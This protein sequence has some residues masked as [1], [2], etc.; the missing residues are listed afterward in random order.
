MKKIHI[1]IPSL[2][3][4]AA[5]PLATMVGCEDDIV[6]HVK[7]VKIDAPSKVTCWKNQ[8]LQLTCSVR[9]ENATNK[10]VKWESLNANV[11][12]I[13]EEGLVTGVNTGTT[14][15]TVQTDDGKYVDSCEIEIFAPVQG[16]TIDGEE[17]K[18]ITK[19]EQTTL[20]CTIDPE[21]AH[22]REVSWESSNNAVATID[23]ATGVV[24]AVGGGTTTITVTTRDG[25]FTD[26]CEI[27]VISLVES[28]SIADNIEQLEVGDTNQ[29]HYNI[30]P[31]DATDK[32]VTWASSNT[33]VANV[34][35]NGLVT[36]VAPGNATITVTTNDGQKT[37]N[38]TLNVVAKDTIPDF[39]KCRW[40]KIAEACEKYESG[41]WTIEQFYQ[42]FS[43][44]GTQV[45]S[46]DELIGQKRSVFVNGI[47]HE[48]IVLDFAKDTINETTP[49]ALTFQFNNLICGKD[50]ASGAKNGTHLRTYWSFYDEG[51]GNY[52]ES[53]LE[54]AINGTE[55]NVEWKD[56]NDEKVKKEDQISVLAMLE[57]SD[58][59]NLAERIKPVSRMALSEAGSWLAIE[60]QVK[61]FPP[62]LSN[63]F[64]E[65]GLKNAT[66][67]DIKRDWARYITEGPKEATNKQYAY[68][69]SYI[70]DDPQGAKAY[71]CLK[72]GDCINSSSAK[73][74]WTSTT[75]VKYPGESF[76]CDDAGRTGI[77]SIPAR[78]GVAPCFCL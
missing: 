22:D 41:D 12:T 40:S 61:L 27:E 43:I 69:K 30:S 70:A 39:N 73:S 66:D 65:T 35:D 58:N 9:P 55:N 18:Q 33:S 15:I 56:D 57:K 42:H 67:A 64:S 21:D 62:S 48:V 3:A 60:K 11:A 36:T 72:L 24:N 38:Y 78:Y 10:G 47:K 76:A 52:W 37:A 25:E 74:H 54:K 46:V 13:N 63:I 45:T 59:D 32:S 7:G 14:L 31:S 20:T 34:D 5:M 26:T 77:Q 6:L 44:N 29:L 53:N 28:V 50:F 2:I 68:Y 49:A 4:T 16:V 75:C 19:G 1:L 71:D 8:T 17:H 51:A 23:S